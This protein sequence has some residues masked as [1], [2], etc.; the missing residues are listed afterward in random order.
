[1]KRLLYVRDRRP[2]FDVMRQEFGLS[3]AARRALEDGNV[4]WRVNQFVL[5]FYTLTPP[6][7]AF[8]ELSGHAWVPI[9]DENTL[10]L[11]FSYHPNE[12]LYEKTRRLFEDGHK[13]RETGH[14]SQGAMRAD[15]ASRPYAGYWT[16]FTRENDFKLDYESQLTTWFSGIPGLW[17]QDAAC[18]SGLG[19]VYDRTRERLGVQRQRHRDGPPGVVGGAKAHRQHGTVPSVVSRPDLS[20]VRAVALQLTPDESWSGPSGRATHDR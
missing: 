14:P 4:Y 15:D 16:S 8:P 6:Q 5:P 12:P 7:S 2:T 1:M 19:P 18:Q 3:I 10:V 20:M 17:V 11:M 9:D 13:G